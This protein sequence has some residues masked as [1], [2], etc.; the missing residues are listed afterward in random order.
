[1]TASDP[2]TLRSLASAAL[3]AACVTAS[4]ADDWPLHGHD[5]ANTRY[6]TL[7]QINTSN[8]SRLAPA[9]SFRTGMPGSFQ[10]TPLVVDEIGRAHV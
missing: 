2:K 6:S 8:I 10:A 1:M 9:W 3:V 4:A 5:L 7:T